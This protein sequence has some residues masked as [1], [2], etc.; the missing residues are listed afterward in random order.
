VSD[1]TLATPVAFTVTVLPPG[2]IPGTLYSMGADC[3]ITEAPAIE[4]LTDATVDVGARGSS[5]WVERCTVYVFQLPDLGAVANPFTAATFTF[6]AV[7]KGGSSLRGHDLYG[8]GRRASSTVL[9]TDFYS[10]TSMPDPTDATRLQQTIM[11]NS[12]PLGLVTTT[13]G[14]SANLLAYL[15]TQYAG[16]AGAGQ[17]VFLRINSRDVKTGVSYATLTMS[18]GG[19]AGPPDTRPRITY[20]AAGNS[21]PYMSVI[22]DQVISVDTSTG[23]LAFT[24]GDDST[25]AGSITLA[26]GSSNPTLVPVAKIVFGGSDSNRTVTVTPAV[27]QLGVTHIS[28]I[29]NDGILSAT[30]TFTLTVQPPP[31]P[32]PVV[33][34]GW[35]TWVDA[36]GNVYHA[37]VLN[38]ATGVAVATADTVGGTYPGWA[39]WGGATAHNSG[40]S[41]DGTWGTVTDNPP[42][43]GTNLTDAVGLL[44][45]TP[46]GEMTFTIV[47]TSG[48]PWNLAGFH[49]DGVRVRTSAA[50]DWELSILAGSAVTVGAVTNG[51]ILSDGSSPFLD[52]EDVDVDLTGLA[53][54]TL[55]NGEVV[56]VRLAWTGGA[57]ANAGGNNTMIDNVALTGVPLPEPPL[58]TYSMSG[59]DMVL[60][61]SESGFKVQTRT[62]LTSG[63]WSNLQGGNVSPVNVTPS[64]ASAFFRLT[65]Q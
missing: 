32:P 60:S 46:S 8:L 9:T 53:D 21:P 2:I 63:T 25:A 58:L 52:R 28:I 61:W 36:G 48:G 40:A 1:G 6:N 10:Q 26:K 38:G 15:N 62:N 24:V 56:I 22:S 51:T 19:V 14:G 13:A 12:T 29:A 45:N 50:D 17:Y 37:T 30:N 59:E 33:M 20:Q 39:N 31:P 23:P 5:P 43:A 41:V 4:K 27:G 64:E 3:S 16:G 65:E 54:R 55:E 35:D 47:N 34:A 18:E 11:N 44:N 49:F 7:T 57:G 42:G